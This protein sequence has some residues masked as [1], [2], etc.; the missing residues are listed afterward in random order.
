VDFQKI[1][2]YEV[3]HQ[4]G[5]GGMGQVFLGHHP[6]LP[7]R[8]AMKLLD[9]GVSR[10]EEFKTRF[11]READLL[12]QLSHP[13]IVTLFD[14]GEFEGRLW[15]TMEFIDG[16]DAAALVKTRGRLSV[17]LALALIEGAGAALDHAW[18][19]HRITHRDV[20]PANILVALNGTDI[21]TVKLADF[22]IAKAAGESTSLTSTGITI[23]TV[24]YL[25]PEAIEGL[26]L[27]NRA[28]IYSLGCTAF[29]LLAGTPPYSGN[30]IT[31]LMSAHLTRRTPDITSR[32]PGLPKA[33]NAVFDRALAKKPG[34]RYQSCA[35]FVAD[36]R[37]AGNGRGGSASAGV[38]ASAPTVAAP[39][40]ARPQ[41]GTGDRKPVSS[42]RRRSAAIFAAAV[43]S[44]LVVAA[45]VVALFAKSGTTQQ[46]APA[47]PR[48]QTTGEPSGPV[49][50]AP[51]APSTT[52]A[53]AVP[54]AGF[55]GEWGQ[56]STSVTLAPD[57]TAHYAVWSGVA[58]GTSW[59]A[60]W[61]AE[62]STT[63][64]VVLATRLESHG[65][66]ST[67]WLNR[68]QGEAFTFTLRPDGY[69]TITDESGKPVTLC[70]R[71]TGFR[72]TEGLCGA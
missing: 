3:I 29:E 24:S 41:P 58:N 14:R 28:D 30:S 48:T 32:A 42:A 59:S 27:D 44:V 71:G 61:S 23:G 72:D 19:K 43:T 52:T 7:R 10:N 25:S 18:R 46:I 63:A 67:L 36:L 37:S 64:L 56:H 21:D 40:A 66:T 50:K 6:R 8:D 57:G 22:G 35:A 11:R 69:A 68:Y 65:D 53:P 2:D 70:P 15:I 16:T 38:T 60:T 47:A 13:N 62:S 39:T 17:A 26:D 9:P 20:K 55:Y 5:A 34:D 54:K 51:P 49:S 12:A 31:A 4:L 1:A 45:I 33:L